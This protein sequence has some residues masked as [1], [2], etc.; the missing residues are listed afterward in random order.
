MKLMTLI[1][2]NIAS[3]ALWYADNANE[4]DQA[5]EDDEAFWRAVWWIRILKT[6]VFIK[7]NTLYYKT[8][9]YQLVSSKM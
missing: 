3:E 5:D 6:T 2:S 8:S 7:Y 4:T 1:K 9:C